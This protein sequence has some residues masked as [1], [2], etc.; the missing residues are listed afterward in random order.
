M[1]STVSP[2]TTNTFAK[3]VS[4]NTP[5]DA[6]DQRERKWQQ[7]GGK[8]EV[9]KATRR[10]ANTAE[11]VARH[12]ESFARLMGH[13]CEHG[14]KTYQHNNAMNATHPMHPT[15]ERERYKTQ[16]ASPQ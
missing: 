10:L 13:G 1:L 12:T 3:Q 9:L 2:Y 4:N 15:S 6:H 5:Q 8:W 14:H 16:H 11:P 7:I